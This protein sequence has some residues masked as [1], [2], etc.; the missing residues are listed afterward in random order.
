MSKL[1]ENEY[2]SRANFKEKRIQLSSFFTAAQSLKLAKD[3]LWAQMGTGDGFI[4]GEALPA[5]DY[6][7]LKM[8]GASVPG[9][10]LETWL[11]HVQNSLHEDLYEVS[12]FNLPRNAILYAFH[13]D[14]LPVLLSRKFLNSLGAVWIG[15]HGLLS[16]VGSFGGFRGSQ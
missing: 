1:N 4:T 2:V 13:G 16:Y 8:I 6:S 11:A 3:V 9:F 15:Y 12:V 14:T 7:V 10:A 5:N